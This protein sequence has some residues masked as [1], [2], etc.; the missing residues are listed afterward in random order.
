MRPIKELLLEEYWNI[1]FREA[2]ENDFVFVN[3]NKDFRTLKESKRYWYADPFLFEYEGEIWLFTEAFDNKTEK[4]LIACSKYEN[5]TFSFPKIV[6]EEDFHLSYPFVYEENGEVF[7]IPETSADGCIQLYKA[8]NFP[9]KWVKHKELVRVEN[10]VDTVV[11]GKKLITSVVTD[12]SEKRVDIDIY[13]MNGELVMKSL[14][15][16]SQQA[17]GAGRVVSVD[18]ND[19]RPAQD[20]TGGVY[21]A[22]LVFYQIEEKDGKFSETQMYK[23]SPKD[24]RIGDQKAEGVHTYARTKNI[25]VLDFKRRRLNLRRIL[26]IVQKKL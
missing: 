15:K 11:Y 25:E 19:I 17:R 5:G 3:K 13:A 10:A 16:D 24:F 6:L 9:E 8:V 18:G 22:G 12:S 2:K 21:G 14:H 4:G 7:M 23:L 20:C 1:A 26:W